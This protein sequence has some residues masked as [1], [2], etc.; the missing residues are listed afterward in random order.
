MASTAEVIPDTEKEYEIVAGQPE[1][2]EMGGA[3]H[4]RVGVRLIARLETHVEANQLGAVYG[5]D[6]TFRIGENERM[7]DVAFISASRIP[8][9][10]DP[11][12]P[13][14]I[15]PDLAVEII[16]PNDIYEKVISK[17]EEYL[18]AGVREVW[19]I[20]PRNRTVSIYRSPIQIIV[21]QEDDE[22]DGGDVVPGFRCRVGEL[23]QG[24]V[25]QAH[26]S[27]RS[28]RK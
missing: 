27:P 10:G 8:E 1:E 9:E 15:P 2:K 25:S 26:S 16:S 3:R 5:P 19:L 4:S 7:P 6:A 22:I 23:F 12:G 11:E 28:L 21:L 13:W 14:P 17:V 20:S 24:P 18:I